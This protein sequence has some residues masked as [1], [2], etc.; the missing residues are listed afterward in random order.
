MRAFVAIAIPDR[1]RPNEPAPYRHP[2]MRDFY[3][4]WEPSFQHPDIGG[5]ATDWIASAGIKVLTIWTFYFGPALTV[6]LLT[7]RRILQ[8]QK[9]RPLLLI[10]G[11][12]VLGYSFQTFLQAHYVAPI[13]A[14]V[15]AILILGMRYLCANKMRR[16][17][18]GKCLVRS[19]V[20]ACLLMVPIA[21][22]NRAMGGFSVPEAPQAWCC[23]G[24]G[25]VDRVAILER[26]TRMGGKHL[27]VVRY[28]DKHNVHNEWVY[29]EADIDSARVVWA[30]EMDRTRNEKLIRYFGDRTVWLLEPD[31]SP[32]K[33]TRYPDLP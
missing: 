11:F 5:P 17:V 2:E 14:P 32:P 20:G 16:T 22:V 21:I 9:Y 18:S 31:E 8:S 3:T 28:S 15:Y 13:T 4:R 19:V 26:L 29:N 10:L 7:L 33:L 1:S 30:R 27:V 6:P 25:L 12:S 23:S 24:V